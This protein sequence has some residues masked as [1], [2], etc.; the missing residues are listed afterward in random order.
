MVKIYKKDDSKCDD[1]EKQ[2]KYTVSM[3]NNNLYL[4][5]DHYNE[6]LEQ[7]RKKI[8]ILDKS[9]KIHDIVEDYG[10]IA[11]NKAFLEKEWV[12]EKM[13]DKNVTIADNKA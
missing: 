11:G 3:K 2:H 13:E 10:S 1:C 8:S 12:D 4:C 5:E 9:K 7:F 6:L